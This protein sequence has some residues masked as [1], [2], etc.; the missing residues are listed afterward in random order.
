MLQRLSDAG[1]VNGQ[2]VGIDATTLEA[3][4]ALRSIVHRDTGAGYET[5]LRQLTDGGLGH[6][7]TDAR[8]TGPYGPQAPEEGVQRR[9]DAS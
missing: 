9:L 1:L 6:R 5:F 4:A 2:T 3:N 8:R 7:H